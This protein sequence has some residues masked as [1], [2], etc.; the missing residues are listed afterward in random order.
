M[1]AE[2]TALTSDL[3]FDVAQWY[4]ARG[5]P[6]NATELLTLSAELAFAVE[7]LWNEQEGWYDNLYPDGSR[8]TVF[9]YKCSKCSAARLQY[10]QRRREEWQ[11]D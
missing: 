2:I 4:L 5:E 6:E 9:T 3:S 10:P 7:S 11:R 1:I 8:H